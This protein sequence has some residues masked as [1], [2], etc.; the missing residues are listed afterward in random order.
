MARIGR[1]LGYLWG[2][3]LVLWGG[4]SVLWAIQSASFSVAADPAAQ[5]MYRLRAETLFPIGVLSV[6]VGVL[7]VCVLYVS[8][9][10]GSQ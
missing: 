5:A 8:G 4:Y 3:L 9:R 1:V 2:V 6:A 10:R 7:S